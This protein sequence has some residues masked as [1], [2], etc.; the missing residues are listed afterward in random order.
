MFLFLKPFPEGLC[1]KIKIEV[2]HMQPGD[3]VPVRR[4][5]PEVKSK[6]EIKSKC[7]MWHLSSQS[8]R[9]VTAQVPGRRYVWLHVQLLLQKGVWH[10][11]CATMILR[12]ST[13]TYKCNYNSCYKTTVPSKWPR[14]QIQVTQAASASVLNLDTRDGAGLQSLYTPNLLWLTCV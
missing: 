3:I 2:A 8:A 4:Q 11:A 6:P 12:F 14:Q 13:T 9:W 5:T 1:S 10:E 7:G